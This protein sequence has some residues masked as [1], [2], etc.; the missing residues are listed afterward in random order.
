VLFEAKWSNAHTGAKLKRINLA[1]AAAS[2]IEFSNQAW[3]L[4]N[5]II[6]RGGKVTKRARKMYIELK[7]KGEIGYL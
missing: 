4:P 1:L 7:R 3:K 2:I 6:A 5:F